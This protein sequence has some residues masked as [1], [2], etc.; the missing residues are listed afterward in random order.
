[1]FRVKPQQSAQL[2][3]IGDQVRLLATPIRHLPT[4]GLLRYHG[5]P[6]KCHR[7]IPEATDIGVMASYSTNEFK[8]GLKVMLDGD[9]CSIIE[10]EFVKPGHGQ[11]FNL[12]KLRN[13]KKGKVWERTFKSGDSLEGA[14]VMDVEM[15]Y[16]YN[17]GEFWY[18][19]DPNTFDQKPADDAA[20][21]D[22]KSTRLNSSHVSISY[23]VFCLKK[24][25]KTTTKGH[26]W[27]I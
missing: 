19:M 4:V 17:D 13:L 15:Q 3:G 20:V 24:K 12:V 1:C 22:R 5:Q 9:P 2:R 27:R 23:A 25:N 16:I 21:G 14:D 18:F 26:G 8:S 10:N 7:Y 11:A 6:L